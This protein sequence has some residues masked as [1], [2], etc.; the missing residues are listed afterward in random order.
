MSFLKCCSCGGTGRGSRGSGFTES[1]IIT[2]TKGVHMTFLK[3]VKSATMLAGIVGILVFAGGVAAATVAVTSSDG[4]YTNITLETAFTGNLVYTLTPDATSE[5][6]AENANLQAAKA[7]FKPTNLPAGLDI[8]TL[9]RT[10]DVAVT[11]TITGTPSGNASSA[12]NLTFGTLDKALFDAAAGADITPTGTISFTVKNKQVNVL[13]IGVT[14]HPQAK[15]V[16][17]GNIGSADV[18]TVVATI[19]PASPAGSRDTSLVYRWFEATSTTAVPATDA[20]APG[21]AWTKGTDGASY[22]IPAGLLNTDSP[23]YYY[24]RIMSTIKKADGVTDSVTIATSNVATVTVSARPTLKFANAAAVGDVQA[25]TDTS[26]AKAG[27]GNGDPTYIAGSVDVKLSLAPVTYTGGA[28]GDAASYQWFRNSAL[29]NQGG[30]EVNGATGADFTVPATLEP[31]YY[32]FFCEARGKN[33]LSIRT[34][35]FTVK[36]TPPAN[37]DREVLPS[38]N[39]VQFQNGAPAAIDYSYSTDMKLA[40][41]ADA[42]TLVSPAYPA[43]GSLKFTVEKI[44]YEGVGGFANNRQY[45]YSKT[46]TKGASPDNNGDILAGHLDDQKVLRAGKYSVTVVVASTTTTGTPAKTYVGSTNVTWTVNEKDLNNIMTK[47]ISPAT[48]VYDGKTKE[49]VITLEDGDSKKKVTLD[50]TNHFTRTDG[51]L[52]N[53]GVADVSF[54]GKNNYKGTLKL[55]FAITKRVITVDASGTNTS[56]ASN[57]TKTYDGT[58]DVTYSPAN[59]D[60]Q[61]GS[62]VNAADLVKGSGYAVSGMKFDAAGA[63]DSRS[64]TGTV[65]L[66]TNTLM[67]KNYSF[68]NGAISASFTVTG[69][70]IGKKTPVADDFTF[71]IPLKRLFTGQGQSIGNVAWN[72]KFSS[73]GDTRTVYYNETG[74]GLGPVTTLPVKAA[75]YAVTLNVSGSNNFSDQTGISLGNFIIGDA[76]EPNLVFMD[77]TNFNLSTNA[78]VPNKHTATAYKNEA[79]TLKAIAFRPDSSDNEVRPST[80]AADSIVYYKS[81]TITYRWF[82]GSGNTDTLKNGRTPVTTANYTVT[83]DEE[84]QANTPLIYTVEATYTNA[85]VQ[86]A[87]TA[88]EELEVTVAA[89]RID[90][91]DA[92]VVVSKTGGWIYTGV[93]AVVDGD[94]DVTVTPKGETQKLTF[95]PTNDYTIDVFGEDAGTGLVTITGVNAYKG[96]T[97]G[98]FE[99][100]KAVTTQDGLKF[101]PASTSVQYNG[102][103]QPITVTPKVGG[104]LGTVK[105]TYVNVNDEENPVTLTAAPKNAGKYAALIWIEEGANYTELDTI[106]RDYTITKR[107]VAVEDLNFTMPKNGATPAPIVAT[108]KNPMDYKGTISTLYLTSNNTTLTA[109]PTEEG[110]YS[111]KAKLSGDDNFGAVV[112]PLGQLEIGDDGKVVVSVAEANREV[113]KAGVKEVVTV[114]PV[115]VTASAKLTAGPSPVKLGGEITF[116]LKSNGSIY[117]F[118]ASGSNVAKVSAKSGKAV[119]NLKDKKGVTV[120]EGTYVAVAKDG[121][122]KVSFKFSVV[123]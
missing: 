53:A 17:E 29:S 23:K 50:A 94:A 88:T 55:T 20:A 46:G 68:A 113:P 77:S 16:V 59:V 41:P 93:T 58:T 36:V 47:T 14:T 92:V 70:T 8:G 38:I 60:V 118:D 6:F 37:S 35:A 65:T 56:N 81:G 24:V 54:V 67:G 30:V 34:F 39:L 33:A 112:V 22:R 120:S 61:F 63:G 105:I 110:V 96:K 104:G 89:E 79:I 115:K 44:I 114:A 15:T 9:T 48:A 123:K 10:S 111:V 13:T 106:E 91:S 78:V 73:T 107:F 80:G 98:T 117:I 66:D 27:Q 121:R 28:Q 3:S 122:E 97:S 85:G 7:S 19:T 116:F 40:I 108:L 18:L 109:V 72:S 84:T 75:T 49:P 4:D 71:K 62:L 86:V 64:V 101:S 51:N 90:I 99:I 100:A 26:R 119:W 83:F 69:V 103:A 95:G 102:A 31:G 76:K 11:V 32:F 25:A 21:S 42:T 5:K 52:T 12:A 1:N 82:K 45:V 74:A 57:L 43:T 87:K 2:I